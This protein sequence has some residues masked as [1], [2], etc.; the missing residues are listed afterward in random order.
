AISDIP[1]IENVLVRVGMDEKGDFIL[2]PTV[3]EMEKSDLDLLVACTKDNIAMIEAGANIITEEKM[4]EAM[5]FGLENGKKFIEFIEKIKKEVGKEKRKYEVKIPDE[6]IKPLIEE[7]YSDQ[8]EEII[9][10]DISKGDRFAKMGDLS[11]LAAKEICEELNSDEEEICNEKE[12]M[13]VF[14]KV[15]KGVIRYNILKKER[16]IKGRGLDEIRPLNCEVDILPRV[17][18]VGLFNRGETQGLSVVTLGGP[19]DVQIIDGVEGD[20]TKNYFHHY[21]FPPFSVGEVSNRLMTGNREIGHGALAERAL[22]PVLPSVEDFPYTIRVVS[23]ILS[24]N[25]SSSMA[26]T[27]GSTLSLMD[28]G[29][30]IKEPVSGIAMGLMTDYETGEYK[31]LTDL[32]DEEDFGGDMD[33]KVTGTKDGITCIQMD[34][35]LTGIKM[36]IFKEAFEKARLGRLKVMDAMLSAIPSVRKKLKDTAPSLI[37][38]KISEDDIKIVIGKGGETIN[39]IIAEFGCEINISDEGNVVITA[40]T[41]LLG[42]AAKKYIETLLEKPEPGKIYEGKV[43]KV[44]EFGIFVQFM[45]GI[46]GL[47]H[48]SQISDKR[49]NDISEMPKEGDF[50]KVKLV[51][52][53]SQGRNKLTMKGLN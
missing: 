43:V 15:Q 49:I 46:D 22:K 30:P 4:I 3:E 13:E 10:E 45:T 29:V 27:C 52:I 42:N 16:R 2:N 20:S 19:G 31:V 28:A 37:S 7:K 33:F 18:G 40:E 41:Q 53:D 1:F 35:K 26:A 11:K 21:N 34:I 6:R 25:G 5:E 47:V 38:F 32:Q 14:N 8:I 50:V 23:E 51:E 12:V 44:M 9:Y 48:I 17:H 24:S 36:E 39:K